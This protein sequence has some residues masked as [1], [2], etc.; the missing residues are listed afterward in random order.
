MMPTAYKYNWTITQYVR[1]SC[2]TRIAE[3]R[4]VPYKSRGSSDAEV[5]QSHTI[6]ACLVWYNNRGAESSPLQES[7]KFSCRLHTSVT[8]I[9]TY[10]NKCQYRYVRASCGTRIA[11]PRAVPYNKSRG[12]SNAQYPGHMKSG[13]GAKVLC[14]E[15]KLNQICGGF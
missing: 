12:G 1:A 6:C 5:L 8:T 13:V 4:A 9:I 11:E 7:R 10:N 2:G 15:F 3:P 14:V